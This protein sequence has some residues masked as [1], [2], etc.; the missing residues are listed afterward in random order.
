MEE[1][2]QTNVHPPHTPQTI[3]VNQSELELI[4]LIRSQ[5]FDTIKIKT[6]EGKID[7]LECSECKQ[8]S[9]RIAD[10][11]KETLYQDIEIKVNKGKVCHI[12]QT[13]KIKY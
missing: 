13:K 5:K 7:F 1:A 9:A 2:N 4:K 12:R 11:M 3:Q 10:L 8:T 6:P